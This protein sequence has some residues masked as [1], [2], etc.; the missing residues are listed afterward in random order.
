[1]TINYNAVELEAISRDNQHATNDTDDINDLLLRVHV[2]QTN[3]GNDDAYMPI[4]M[5]IGILMERQE[6][7]VEPTD[8]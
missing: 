4:K 1:L 8:T 7:H 6:T 5:D 3:N 2:D